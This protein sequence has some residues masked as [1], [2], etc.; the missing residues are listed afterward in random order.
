M[1][2]IDGNSENRREGGDLSSLFPK[3]KSGEAVA[4]APIPVINPKSAKVLQERAAA[5]AAWRRKAEVVSQSRRGVSAWEKHFAS[6]ILANWRG[7]LSERQQTCL[8]KAYRKC[9]RND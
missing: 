7:E 2:Y 1:I 5:E 4:S 8:G 3:N 9:H 6:D